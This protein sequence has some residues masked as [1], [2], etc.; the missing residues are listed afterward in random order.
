ML[1]FDCCRGTSN[2]APLC[3]CGD[4]M[5]ISATTAGQYT[6]GFTCDECNRDFDAGLER[7]WCQRCDKDICFG[8][9]AKAIEHRCFSLQEQREQRVQIRDTLR[10]YATPAARTA[11]TL[12][13]SRGSYWTDALVGAFREQPNYCLT[14]ILM[15][16]DEKLGR[17]AQ[18]EEQRSRKGI[19]TCTI[20]RSDFNPTGW[21]KKV[22]FKR[23][24]TNALSKT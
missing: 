23:K 12:S 15:L 6:H 18:A 4:R 17:A 13:T 14:E 3:A 16:A 5:V 8:C 22:R 7:W 1:F 19:Q 11:Q 24:A 20:N 10:A 2:L 9:V 21:C